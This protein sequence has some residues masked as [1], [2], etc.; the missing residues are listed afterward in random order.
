M[1]R[2]GERGSAQPYSCGRFRVRY[3]HRILLF[4]AIPGSVALIPDYGRKNSRFPMHHLECNL[5]I[6][7][8]FIMTQR[9]R[10]AEIPGSFPVVRE[11]A[12]ALAIPP[13]PRPTAK[14]RLDDGA[15]IGITRPRSA[16]R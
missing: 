12:A 16:A 14:G 15:A 10:T 7:C 5:L 3:A 4:P 13:R 9:L 11:F 8:Q 1:G 2:A 6:L